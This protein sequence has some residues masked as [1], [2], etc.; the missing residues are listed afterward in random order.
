MTTVVHV[1]TTTPQLSHLLGCTATTLL[2]WSASAC[3]CPGMP[4]VSP[5]LW[6]ALIHEQ[7]APV[8]QLSGE[9]A[10]ERISLTL[11]SQLSGHEAS[12]S[13]SCWLELNSEQVHGAAVDC[14]ICIG[15]CRLSK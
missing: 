8:S 1:L 9:G 7:L 4:V 2:Q 3:S 6:S 12:Y 14:L 11:M 15:H 10:F 13:A 5:S